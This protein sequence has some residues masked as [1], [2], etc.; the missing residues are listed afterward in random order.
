MWLGDCRHLIDAKHVALKVN[1][2]HASTVCA[3]EIVPVR[4]ILASCWSS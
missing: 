1:A 3:L 4:Q 2:L